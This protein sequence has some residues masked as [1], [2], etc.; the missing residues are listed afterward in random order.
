MRKLL[1]IVLALALTLTAAF[2]VLKVSDNPTKQIVG[3]WT[4][5]NTNFTLQFEKGGVAKIPVEAFDIEFGYEG[6]VE[7]SY[8]I[9]KADKKITFSFSFLGLDYDLTYFFNI[10]NDALTLRKQIDSEPNV[11]LKSK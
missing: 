2:L 6:D 7:G 5:A 11:Y 1:A 10:K 9:D 4:N 8:T 3:K